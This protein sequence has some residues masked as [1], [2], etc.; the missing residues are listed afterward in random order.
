MFQKILIANRGEIAIRVARTCRELGIA[1]VAVY[2]EADLSSPHLF[3]ADEAVCIGPAQA[4]Q[5]YLNAQALISAAQQTGAQ[6]IH[7]GYG[8]LSENSA[9]AQLVREAGL[10][11]IGPSSE[12]LAAVGNKIFARQTVTKLGVPVVPALEHPSRDPALLREQV[13]ALGYPVLIKAASGGGGKGMRIVRQE[14][15]LLEA[16]AA[17]E[18]EAVS[19]FAEGTIYI[20]RYIERPR[21]IEVQILGDQH[22]T[23]VHLGERECSIQRRYQ[24]ILEETPSPA[25]S[26]QLRDAM[27]TAA[28]TVAKAA[29][30]YNAGTVEFILDDQGRFYFL[31]VNARLQVEHPITEWITGLDL[32]REQIRIAAGERL[33]FAQNDIQRRGHAFE[34]RVYAED[35]ARGFLPSPGT[36][37][38]WNAPTGPGIRVDAGVTAQTVVSVYYDPLIA[39]L[40]TWGQDREQARR[41]MESALRQCAVLGPTT[42][43]PFLLDLVTH[44]AFIAGDTHTGFLTEHLSQWQPT[45]SAG[46]DL[47]AALTIAITH[48]RKSRVTTATSVGGQPVTASPW[49]QLGGW[50]MGQ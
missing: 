39:K 46:H 28:L 29:G 42:N 47:E 34:C 30:Y 44:P 14:K 16:A 36:V 24:K 45:S 3:A 15:E 37:L 2:S 13:Q 10:T 31:E 50:R 35:P 48:A 5:S 7:P 23:L 6:A 11:F 22:G 38:A 8:F 21:H 4:S 26:P 12:S 20:E 17:A 19:A 9:F 27:T 32:V 40:S 1:T 18:R 25:V 43:L 41:R 33:G 49:Q